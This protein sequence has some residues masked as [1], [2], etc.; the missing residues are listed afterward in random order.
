MSDLTTALTASQISQGLH[1]IVGDKGLVTDSETLKFHNDDWYGVKR[2]F[3]AALVKPA[4]SEE[5]AAV[6]RFCNANNLKIIPQGGLTGLMAGT[7]P[8]GKGDE[9]LVS[10]A[11]MNRVLD[12]NPDGYTMTVEAGTILQTIQDAAAQ[13]DRFFPLRIGSQGSCMIGGNISTNAGGVNVLYYGNTRTLVLGL[14]VVMPD[15]RIWDG[16]RALK[17]DNT[18]YHLKELFIGAEGTLGIVTKAVLK[19][20]PKP[21]DAATAWIAVRDPAAAIQMLS[22]ARGASSDTVTSCELL[23]AF[24]VECILKYGQ[25]HQRP[26]DG[27]YDWHVL[28]E[29]SSPRAA[30]EDA[31]GT[32]TERMEGFLADCL[33]RGLALDATLAQSHAQA[34]SMWA[35]REGSG[36]SMRR[37]PNPNCSFD[38]SV[39]V[40]KI[41]DL[42]ARADAAALKAVP[43]I[44]PRPGGH[45]GDG[46]IHYS[47]T[48]P[49]HITSAAEFAPMV[50]VLDKIVCDMVAEIGGSIS[51]EHGIGVI[52]VLELEHYRSEVELDIMRAIKKA[53]DPKDLMN[54]GKVIRLDPNDASGGEINRMGIAG[55]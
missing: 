32:M 50:K 53:L 11:R 24:S 26:I 40:N 43:G 41:P 33:E 35:I 13:H 1:A 5:V 39:A 2:G 23:N 42:I 48:A 46:N 27:Q 8:L 47:F 52:K 9:V 18:G 21:K 22:E 55:G 29:W 49:E 12:V 45:M 16:L 4:T 7:A 34:R 38:V 54:P 25:N 14:E 31:S 51:A 37:Q 30:G 17:K 15:G 44:R 10:L 36:A 20:F 28:M 19:I 6:V 3:A